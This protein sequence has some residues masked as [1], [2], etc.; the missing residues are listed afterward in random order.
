MKLIR[1]NNPFTCIVCSKHVEKAVGSSRDHCPFC[2]SSLHVDLHVP[3]DRM[4]ECKGIM[5]A[6]RI[7]YWK[8]ERYK[9]LFRCNKCCSEQWNIT[10]TDDSPEALAQ[11][12]LKTNQS[13]M[14]D[15]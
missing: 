9:V 1:N 10:A 8:K 4:N 3:G 7:R 5:S 2:I 12:M 14:G 6:T 15:K 11:L 13:L